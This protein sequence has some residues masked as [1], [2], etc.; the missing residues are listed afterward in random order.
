MPSVHVNIVA[1]TKRVAT[2][3]HPRDGVRISYGD[4]IGMTIVYA[5]Y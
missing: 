4:G 2:F 1:S 5:E 3:V